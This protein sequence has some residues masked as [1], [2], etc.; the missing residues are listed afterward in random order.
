MMERPIL[1]LFAALVSASMFTPA[2]PAP[3]DPLAHAIPSVSAVTYHVVDT[4]QISVQSPMGPVDVTAS[5]SATLTAG[6]EEAPGGFRATAELTDFS[7]SV[8]N[9]MM[10]A[11]SM[12]S[13]AFSGAIVVVVGPT[14]VTEL[15]ATPEPSPMAG[16]FSLFEAM[17]YDLFPGLP[18]RAVAAGDTWNDTFTWSASVDGG[19]M[20]TTVA[21][22]F[23]MG[24]E[25][26]VDGRSLQTIALSATVEISASS[27][28]GGMNASQ[29][30]EG[31]VAGHYYWDSAAGLLHSAELVRDY[32]GQATIPGMPPVPMAMKGPQR[33]VRAN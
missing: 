9:P 30:F 21:R 6:F 17:G 28:Q 19:E 31:T 5:A 27:N 18:A 1:T 2:A 32:E 24:E 20:T 4:M 22:S 16:Q 15:V 33:I 12:G 29:T 7:G 26:V 14:G 11:Q 23:T 8:T 13:E 3:Q 25:T 10:G